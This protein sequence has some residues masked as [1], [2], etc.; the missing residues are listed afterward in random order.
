[1]T[2]CGT[3]VTETILVHDDGNHDVNHAIELTRCS[4]SSEFLVSYC[5]DE[6]WYYEFSMK[7]PSDYERIKFCIMENVYKCR[8]MPSLI[9]NLNNIFE[10]YF[11][12]ILIQEERKEINIDMS[13]EV[14]NK[15]LN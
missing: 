4:Y 2:Y 3:S 11:A 10:N 1:M 9:E 12:D 6:C 8:N 13:N 14:I 7:D 15:F 5:G